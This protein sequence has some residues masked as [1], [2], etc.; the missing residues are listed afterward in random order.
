MGSKL[1]A[2]QDLLSQQEH[3]S[4]INYDLRITNLARF[5]YK[6]IQKHLRQDE[7][8]KDVIPAQAGIS[9]SPTRRSARDDKVI[10]L[11]DIGA[12]N[13]LFLKFFKQKGIH[14]SGIELEKDQVHAMNKDFQLREVPV[15]QGDITKLTGKEEY[16]IVIASDVIEHIEDDRSAL[17]NLWSFVAP[18]GLLI[19]TVP[20]H[21][22]LY[23]KRD[24]AWGHYRRYG[25]NDL[26]Q[27]VRQLKSA[28]IEF[29]T[30]WNIIGYF[31]YGF[32]E[33]ILHK[34]I[35][36]KMRYS[37]SPLSKLVRFTLDKILLTEEMIG[38]LPVGL[39]LIAG[40]RK[41]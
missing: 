29:T 1:S 12:G 25:R 28:H 21:Q 40:I 2:E 37:D 19:I 3:L 38:G 13:G 4:S 16:D 34:P 22:Y 24:K 23:G 31:A 39:T 20:A 11:I 33:K 35:N 8:T 26:K 7:V 41:K 27:K 36:E 30:F 9:G 5:I 17:Q 32:Y 10:N 6:K 14:V 15:K 18:G